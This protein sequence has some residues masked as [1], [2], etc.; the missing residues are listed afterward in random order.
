MDRV[1]GMNQPI[2]RHSGDPRWIKYDPFRG[3]RV[4]KGVNRNDH[5]NR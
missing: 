3:N 4:I 1:V 5:E 2:L